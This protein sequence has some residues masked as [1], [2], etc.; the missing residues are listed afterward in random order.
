M[1]NRQI[2]LAIQ[3]LQY[4]IDLHL[5][6]INFERTKPAPN[7]ELLYHWEREIEVFTQRLERLEARL[8]A[9]RR[10]GRRG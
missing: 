9:R 1:G 3:G 7:E 8:A 2:R 5:D 10:R 4:Q 6:K